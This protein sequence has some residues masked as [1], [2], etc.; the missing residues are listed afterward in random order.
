LGAVFGHT[1][2]GETTM[3]AG[4]SRSTRKGM[5][6]LRTGTSTPKSVLVGIQ[7]ADAGFGVRA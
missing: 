7:D 5:V 4:L 3:A 2:T 6:V 1:Q